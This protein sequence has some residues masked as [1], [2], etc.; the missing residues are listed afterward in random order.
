MFDLWETGTRVHEYFAKL[1]RAVALGDLGRSASLPQSSARP[2]LFSN[3]VDA[4]PAAG[5]RLDLF[6]S[7]AAASSDHLPRSNAGKELF[8]TGNSIAPNRMPT[9]SLSPSS[10]RTDILPNR[11]ASNWNPLRQAAPWR[12]SGS[13]VNRFGYGAEDVKE[14]K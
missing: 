13:T 3:L 12:S 5:L 4:P 7:V 1:Y 9:A 10:E 6:P 2:D 8:P 11:A 14:R